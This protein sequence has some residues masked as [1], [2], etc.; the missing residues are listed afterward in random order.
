M[1]AATARGHASGALRP[2]PTSFAMVEE[3]GIPFVVRVVDNL[4][5]K[6][7]ARQAQTAAAAGGAAQN[8]FLPCDPDLYVADVSDEHVAV[9]NKFNV[10][11]HHLLI[12]T[13]HFEHQ[14]T[15]LGPADFYALWRC[16]R[17]VDGLGFYNGG[18]VAGASQ[19]HKHLQLAPYPITSDQQ[20]VPVDAIVRETLD[21]RMGS[22]PAFAFDHAI[23]PCPQAWA[24][25]PHLAA[26]ECHARHLDL[27][28]ATSRAAK[29]GV[30]RQTGPYN[31][32]VTRDWMMVVARSE[33]FFE[34]L[35]VNAIGYAGGLLV[36]NDREL[37]RV[38]EVGPLR[39]VASCGTRLT[40]SSGKPAAD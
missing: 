8:P 33:E 24:E 40:G 10:L 4:R 3:L 32:L 6:R 21:A 36:R 2:I 16:L 17:D 11:D 14:E 25:S 7:E 15:L 26:C 29:P 18:V 37:A 22:V 31:L 12:V 5:R 19:E 27:L 1:L 34:G 13:R 35:S 30:M 23:C 28:A 38:R 9:L 20:R 39:I